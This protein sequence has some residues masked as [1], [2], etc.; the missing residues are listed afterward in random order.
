MQ[1]NAFSVASC[2]TL[3]YCATK[4]LKG[5]FKA[6]QT[7]I[8]MRAVARTHE[9]IHHRTAYT[10]FAYTYSPASNMFTDSKQ[11]PETH[12]AHSTSRNCDGDSSV[13]LGSSG[14]TFTAA[15]NNTTCVAN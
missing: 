9:I 7:L 4:S 10:K 12:G 15:D 5:Q 11:T 6:E 3:P 14:L 1:Q 2:P 13:N 8:H